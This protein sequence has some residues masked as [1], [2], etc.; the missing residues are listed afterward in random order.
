MAKVRT[1][2]TCG[3]CG[4]T[5]SK[6]AGQCAGCSQWN[7]LLETPVEKKGSRFSAHGLTEQ[8]PVQRLSEIAVVDAQRIITGVSEFDRVLGGGLVPGGVVLIGG[9]PGIGKSTLLLQALAS[10]ARVQKVLYVSGEESGAQVA[11]RAR[12]LALP[13]QD[14]QLQA[15]IQLEKIQATLLEYKPQIAVID[16]IQTLYSDTLTSAPGSVAQVRECAARLTR[17]AKQAGITI[18]MVGHVTKEGALAGPR[19]L[20]HMVDTVLYFEGDPHSRFRLVRAFKNRFGAVN[21]I[22]VFAMTETG[23]KGVSNPSALF[24]SS[25]EKQIAGSC[26]MVTQEGMR[27]LL[28][29][30]QALVDTSHLTNAR[31]LS[32]GLEHNRL[33]MLLA[34]L[35]R[36]A[37]IAAYD[38]DVFINAVGGVRISEPAA[39]LPVLLA[40]YSSLR[41]KPLPKGLV[42]FGEVGLTGEIRPA[43]RGQDRLREAAKLGFSIAM[44]PKSNRPKQN[45]EGMRVVAVERIDEAIRKLKE[46]DG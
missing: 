44:I 16:S 11:L 9:D 17:I 29:E 34:V 5:T 35:H 21:E 8:A 20:E 36:H 37:G 38:Q 24:L 15:E 13:T 33:A 40:I 39:D 18:I 14:L 1:N 31:R 7:S 23:L 12:R 2:Y 43:P 3:E 45:L 41:N 19:V 46:L 25:H 4:H 26:V 22:G 6:W 10:L 42:V 27:P 30:V 32:V 28:V